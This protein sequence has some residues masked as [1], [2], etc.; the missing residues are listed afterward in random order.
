M[1]MYMYVL[2]NITIPSFL[3]FWLN[4]KYEITN[5]SEAPKSNVEIKVTSST[6]KAQYHG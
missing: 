2:Y 1:Y 5:S 3:D 4:V 6:Q